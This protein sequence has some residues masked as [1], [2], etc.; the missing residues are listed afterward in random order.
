M[1]PELCLLRRRP[2]ALHLR[3]L[4]R[5]E[6]SWAGSQIEG[7]Q[8]RLGNLILGLRPWTVNLGFQ[9]LSAVLRAVQLSGLDFVLRPWIPCEVSDAGRGLDRRPHYVSHWHWN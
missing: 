3:F 7:L 4:L 9:T 5:A 8:N 6:T 2:V 1:R